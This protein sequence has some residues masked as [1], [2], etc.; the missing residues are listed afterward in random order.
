MKYLLFTFIFSLGVNA[1][2]YFENDGSSP[3]TLSEKSNSEIQKPGTKKIFKSTTTTTTE[4]DVQEQQAAGTSETGI[5]NSPGIST[6]Q[7]NT[8][9]NNP[10]SNE[11]ELIEDATLSTG[12]FS[13]TNPGEI[14]AQEEED[15]LDYS[16]TPEKR[17]TKPLGPNKK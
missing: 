12:R 6:D 3:E 1:A 13:P 15:A 16:T 7:M 5:L 17:T 14:E 11:E 8:S 4:S 10:P 9:P 2:E